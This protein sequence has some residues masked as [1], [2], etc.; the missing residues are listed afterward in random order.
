[1]INLRYDAAPLSSLPALPQRSCRTDH[2]H[3]ASGA[4]YSSSCGR[5]RF[6]RP[7]SCGGVGYWRSSGTT[8]AVLFIP[9]MTQPVSKRLWIFEFDAPG[10]IGAAPRWIFRISGILAADAGLWAGFWPLCAGLARYG[11]K[12]TPARAYAASMAAIS[13][14]M[15][16]MFMTRLRL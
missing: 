9:L 14:R 1:M 2:L 15:P 11:R 3:H 13:G 10:R 7:I 5:S 6:P 12:M 16:K 8:I 4:S